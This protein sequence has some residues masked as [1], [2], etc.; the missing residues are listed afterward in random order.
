MRV[1]VLQHD[2]SEVPLQDDWLS[3]AEIA[4]LTQFRFPKRRADWRLGRWTA[5]R[6]VALYLDRLLLPSHLAEIEVHPLPGGAPQAVV[7]GKPAPVAISLSHRSGKAICAVGPEDSMLGCDLEL[8]EPRSAAFVEDYF[9]LGEQD[10]IAHTSRLEQMVLACLLW[11]A[12]ESTL[13]AMQVGLRLDPRALTV[14]RI[15]N[16]PGS[17]TPGL[18][19]L[20]AACH[21][22]RPLSNWNE[23]LVRS[24]TGRLFKGWWTNWNTFLATLVG[25]PAPSYPFRLPYQS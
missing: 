2:A 23:L 19:R 12:K 9:T 14:L 15:D 16:K 1:Y 10:A 4:R 17:A 25:H 3:E 22:T 6:A 7:A 8:V 24:S 11:S 20:N 13:K 5:K 18:A 21:Q